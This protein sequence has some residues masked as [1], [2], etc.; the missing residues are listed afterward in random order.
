M[1]KKPGAALVVQHNNLIEAYYD[2]DLSANEHKIIKYA[3]SKIKLNDTQFPDYSFDV[4][5]FV[6]AAN[7]K[8]GNYY[9]EVEKIADELSKKRIKVKSKEAIGYFP[10]FS[11]IVYQKGV[12]HISFNHHIKDLL[13]Q[14]E[15]TFTNY[16]FEVIT[17][18]KS[19]YSLRLFELLKQYE[20]I[21]YR[22]MKID[23]LRRMLG[24]RDKYSEYSAMKQRVLKKAHS[25]LNKKTKLSFE[26]EEVKEGRKVVAI[27]FFIKSNYK[28]EQLELF[29]EPEVNNEPEV[30]EGEVIEDTSKENI[31]VSH[32]RSKLKKQ[33]IF[34]DD[35]LIEKWVKYGE[36]LVEEAVEEVK[37]KNNIKNYYGYISSI[38]L[39]K[40]KKAKAKEAQINN[41]TVEDKTEL[42]IQSIIENYKTNKTLVPDWL[43]MNECIPLLEKELNISREE[44]EDI[45]MNKG[46]EI[47]ERI[48]EAILT[49][50]SKPN[51]SR[52]RM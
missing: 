46:K 30:I 47:V 37:G 32:I 26:Y 15:Q 27:D 5:E 52:S 38:L 16:P 28:N 4:K 2:M 50:Q 11:A 25:E 44:A 8:G 29:E 3:I 49:N 31:F 45:W 35:Y 13:L 34:I 40:K 6:K 36:G 21:G 22:R 1:E 23:D 24:I 18:L 19:A 12:V 33:G 20:K 48:D 42:I 41:M 10:W 43:V 14:L 51:K 17:P 7:V 9:K 39:A